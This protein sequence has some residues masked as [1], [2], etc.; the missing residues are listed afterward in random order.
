MYG[1]DQA[2][3]A[4]AQARSLM[5]Q[6]EQRQERMIRREIAKLQ[7]RASKQPFRP[8]PRKIGLPSPPKKKAPGGRD[9]TWRNRGYRGPGEERSAWNLDSTKIRAISRGHCF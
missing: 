9:V 6:R 2:R 5:H 8:A 7:P 1:I 3:T 4:V